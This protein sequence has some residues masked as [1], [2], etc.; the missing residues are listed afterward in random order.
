MTIQETVKELEKA[1][2][3]YRIQ[4]ME[5]LLQ[6]LKAEV[7]LNKPL[8][9]A[10]QPFQVRTFNLGADVLVDRDLLYAERGF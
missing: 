6:S 4:V 9:Q 1:P 5:L 7:L 2:I 3:G 10:P 8:P